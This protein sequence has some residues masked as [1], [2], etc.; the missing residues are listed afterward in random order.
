MAAGEP[1]TVSSADFDLEINARAKSLSSALQ[2][3][4]TDML[5]F[6]HDQVA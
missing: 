1:G 6:Q 2:A 5:D 4:I 3:T